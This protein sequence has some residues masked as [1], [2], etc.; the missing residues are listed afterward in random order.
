MSIMNVK[1]DLMSLLPTF[2]GDLMCGCFHPCGSL[3][4]SLGYSKK[5]LGSF[6][7]PLYGASKERLRNFQSRPRSLWGIARI[8]GSFQRPPWEFLRSAVEAPNVLL[9]PW[10]IPRSSLGVSKDLLRSLDLRNIKGLP[11]ESRR[12]SLGDSKKLLG[13]PYK[14]LT[15][16]L[17]RSSLETPR[18]S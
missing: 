6:Q 13:S 12:S 7:R 15:Q 4:S 16:R 17:P 5:L 8:P 3:R 10:G 14:S 1:K 11:L 2:F 18:S 9:A